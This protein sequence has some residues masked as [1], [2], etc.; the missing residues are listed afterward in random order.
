MDAL[1]TTGVILLFVLV[2]LGLGIWIFAG[3]LLVGL[4]T[5]V[6]LLHL[7]IGQIGAIVKGTMWSSA[8]SWEISA[9]PLFMWMGDLIFRTD[10][11]QRL[12]RGLSPW[13]NFLPGRLV[14]TNVLGCTLFAAICGSSVATTAT[15]GKITI[16]ELLS[17][18]YDNNLS[19]GSLAA[20]GALG[21][22]IPPSIVMIIYGV[23]TNTSIARLFAA[24]FLPGILCAAL[25][26]GYIVVVSLIKPSL[27][28]VA[29]QRYTRSDLIGSLKDLLPIFI[30]IGVVLGGIYGGI[31]TPNEAAALGL[32][33]TIV[34]ILATRQF[35]WKLLIESMFS[36]VCLTSMLLTIVIT[37]AFMSATISYLH[38]PQ[39]AAAAVAE[40]KVGPYQFLVIL[41][42][43]Y[44][45]LGLFLE[46]VTIFVTT[47]PL[48][49]PVMLHLGFDPVWFG[50]FLVI[51][52]ELGCMHPPVGVN[53]YVLQGLT[54]Q[55]VARLAIAS[56]P[57]CVLLYVSCVLLTFFPQIALW[58]PHVLYDG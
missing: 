36:T 47:L 11:S 29:P 34:M 48:A 9:V 12:F 39:Q 10:I 27:I 38:L 45:F 24:G 19:V 32:G 17:R 44:I 15:I 55:S 14:H 53:I 6:F 51:A 33:A 28:P 31:C 5:L 52:V 8:D 46:G 50:V 54:G 1:I 56:I 21:I 40:A 57:F 13:V 35:T 23:M 4:S 58:L 30:L 26:A 20:S 25:Y 2:Y 42:A 22:M 41:G 43:F 49:F 7:S 16:K 18:G 37:A 3:V